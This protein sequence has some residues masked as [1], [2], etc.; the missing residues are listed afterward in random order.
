MQQ[1]LGL[2]LILALVNAQGYFTLNDE[3]ESIELQGNFTIQPR[4]SGTYPCVKKAKEVTLS[5]GDV[6]T[7]TSP[8]YPAD[9]TS[10]K[11]CQWKFKASESSG[12]VTITCSSFTLQPTNKKGKCQKDFLKLGLEKFCGSNGPVSVTKG[13]SLKLLF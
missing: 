5:P 3:D 12:K 13:R 6:A 11:K 9:Y 1:V 7:F 10:K 2:V 8:G 4:A